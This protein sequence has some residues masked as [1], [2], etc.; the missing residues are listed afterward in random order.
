MTRKSFIAGNW[1]MHK[2]IAESKALAQAI[3]EAE[4]KNNADIMIAPVFTSLNAVAEVVKGSNVIVSAQDCFYEERVLL[5]L[6][7][8]RTKLKKPALLV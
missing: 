6:K 7:L 3:K 4:N 2:N 8:H 5:L 1:K